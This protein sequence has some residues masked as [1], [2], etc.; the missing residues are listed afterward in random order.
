MLRHRFKEGPSPL[1]KSEMTCLNGQ[2]L[3]GTEGRAGCTEHHRCPGKELLTA[4]LMGVFSLLGRR[5]LSER[6]GGH[7]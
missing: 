3:I 2:G 1:N 7:S 6:T 5:L 4:A